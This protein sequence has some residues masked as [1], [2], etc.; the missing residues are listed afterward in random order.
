MARL[1]G[2]LPFGPVLNIAEIEGD[3]HFAE[4]QMIVEIEQPGTAP[5]RVAGVPIKLSLTP[6][7]V[8]RR[9]PLLG[10]DT[11]AFLREAGLSA[12]E[13]AAAMQRRETLAK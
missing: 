6:G 12:E 8:H 3:A 7:G 4:R 1:G 10:E 2:R 11:A 5:I 13:I 9:G